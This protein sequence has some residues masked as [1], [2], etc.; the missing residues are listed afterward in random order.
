MLKLK[1][2][3]VNGEKKR[4]EN[5]NLSR[6]VQTDHHQLACFKNSLDQMDLQL[7]VHILIQEVMAREKIKTIRAFLQKEER[8][9]MHSIT[10]FQWLIKFNKHTAR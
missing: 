7:E 8:E 3:N 4:E 1:L 2:N 6:W 9:I 5:P 10:D